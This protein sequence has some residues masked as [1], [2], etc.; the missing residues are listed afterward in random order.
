MRLD[1]KVALAAA[2]ALLVCGT[3]SATV[4]AQLETAAASLEK[5]TVGG[6]LVALRYDNED[7]PD[8]W[9]QWRLAGGSVTIYTWNREANV[10]VGA[11]ISADAPYEIS[12]NH[13]SFVSSFVAVRGRSLLSITPADTPGYIT[14]EATGVRLQPADR[15]TFSDEGAGTVEGMENPRTQPV[16][17]AGTTQARS[18]LPWGTITVTGDF[19]IHLWDID[20]QV[21]DA[22]GS[23]VYQSGREEE[24]YASG[25]PGVPIGHVGTTHDRDVYL[26][27]TN[28]ELTLTGVA[29]GNLEYFLRDWSAGVP[30]GLELSGVDGSILHE[31]F[32]KDVE[33]GVVYL[34]GPVSLTNGTANETLLRFEARTPSDIV[35]V[36]GTKIEPPVPANPDETAPS[37]STA[38]RHGPLAWLAPALALFLLGLALVG[39]RVRK[40]FWYVRW[41]MRQGHHGLVV[42]EAPRFFE[43]ASKRKRA[44]MMHAMA[45]IAVGRFQEATEFWFSVVDEDRPDEPTW[46]YMAAMALAGL[47]EFGEAMH[48]LD[49]C[50][51]AAPQYLDDI[52]GNALLTR[53]LKEHESGDP[54]SYT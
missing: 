53:L 2:I 21:T 29:A 52:E 3:T 38:V 37:T 18:D 1:V 6:E 35:F 45:L 30:D 8:G 11:P 27:V 14:H 23:H 54:V 26:Y 50:V 22:E 49:R 51:R 5:A 9:Q 28:G 39:V 15:V 43:H 4:I 24:P 44:V 31:S 33:D 17:V 32:S 36:D 42:E 19:R 48:H 41:R 13:D 34:P 16:D 47:G 10:T 7:A 46:D 25:Q 12:N 20:W 40:P